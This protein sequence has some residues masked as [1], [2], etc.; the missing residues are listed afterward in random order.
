M[1]RSGATGDLSGELL[2]GERCAS[3]VDAMRLAAVGLAVMLAFLGGC[4]E[5][6]A[7]QHAGRA[8]SPLSLVLPRSAYPGQILHPVIL[9]RTGG[10]LGYGPGCEILEHRYGRGWRQT[11]PSRAAPFTCQDVLL[12]TRSSTIRESYRLPSDLSPGVYRMTFHGGVT[13]TSSEALARARLTVLP[14]VPSA[15]RTSSPRQ[16]QGR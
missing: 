7:V 6:H 11:T 14:L 3:S 9:N 16:G 10:E 13:S 4:G 2:R 8:E 12:Q 5:L 15:R 1:T